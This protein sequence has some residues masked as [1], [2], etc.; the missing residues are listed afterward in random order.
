MIPMIFKNFNSA[1]YT[2]GINYSSFVTTHIVMITNANVL[3]KRDRA[4]NKT[5]W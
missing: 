2:D 5:K 3:E 1:D 4:R